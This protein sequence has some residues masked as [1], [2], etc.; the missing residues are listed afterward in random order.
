MSGGRHRDRRRLVMELEAIAR[1]ALVRVHR[2]L[3]FRRRRHLEVFHVGEI[4]WAELGRGG[5]IYLYI[6]GVEVLQRVVEVVGIGRPR[7]ERGVA[8]QL[9]AF[10]GFG[11]TFVRR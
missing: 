8:I 9:F 6:A 4:D 5:W 7:G 1:F 3:G 11:V 2:G 10:G